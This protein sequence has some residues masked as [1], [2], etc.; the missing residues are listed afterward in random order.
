MARSLEEMKYDPIKYKTFKEFYLRLLQKVTALHPNLK[1]KPEE[2]KSITSQYFKRKM[3][4]S[5]RQNLNFELS[6]LQN[7]ELVESAQRI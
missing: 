4:I 2:L 6:E 7:F 1:S 3:P 5:V